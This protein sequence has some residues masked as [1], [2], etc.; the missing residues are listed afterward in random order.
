MLVEKDRAVLRRERI[1]DE[2]EKALLTV[3]ERVD[4]LFTEA[5][6]LTEEAPPIA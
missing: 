3:V 4:L 2:I 5:R 1:V 6:L